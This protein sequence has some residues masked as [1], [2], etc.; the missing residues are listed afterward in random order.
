METGCHAGVMMDDDL[1]A[2]GWQ[3]DVVYP[4][5]PSNPKCCAACKGTGE[6]GPEVTTQDDCP[7]CDGTGWKDGKAEWPIHAMPEW[8]PTEAI[9]ER[10]RKALK[11]GRGVR[12]SPE[13]IDVLLA[14]A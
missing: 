10:M 2:E 8:S 3:P 13:E 1:H 11:R 6:A 14:C 4:P 5:C 7:D 9:H 12:L